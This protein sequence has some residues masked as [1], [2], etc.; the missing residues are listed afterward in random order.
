MDF[1]LIVIAV[2]FAVFFLMKALAL[3]AYPKAGASFMYRSPLFTPLS[4]RRSQPQSQKEL[5]RLK[6]RFLLISISSVIGIE[7]YRHLFSSV[8]L[9][10]QAKAWVFAPYI[11][12]FTNLLGT[13]AQ[14]LGLLTKELPADIH[15]HPYRAK[16]IS[17]FWSKRWNTWVG[18]W[19]ASLSLKIFP[20]ART[21]RVLCAFLLSGFFHEAIISLP[22]WLYTKENL[23][24]WMTLFF[25]IQFIFVS[26]DKKSKLSPKLRLAFMWIGILLPMPLFINKSVLAFFG[27]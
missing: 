16:S 24:G 7:F 13:S 5:L 18:D 11:Y 12:I 8:E 14:F 4:L 2:F 19:L 6:K 26:I 23:F 9:G 21:L 20:K 10:A 1:Q 25:F 3:M 27:F 17:E 22:Y 15:N